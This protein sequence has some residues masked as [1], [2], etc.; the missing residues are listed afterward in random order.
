MLRQSIKD[1]HALEMVEFTSLLMESLISGKSL[2]YGALSCGWRPLELLA[3]CAWGSRTQYQHLTDSESRAT[4]MSW[5]GKRVIY[6]AI[7]AH[8]RVHALRTI[9]T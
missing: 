7:R 1:T 3:A 8:R 4:R 5:P 2:D 6:P 9:L